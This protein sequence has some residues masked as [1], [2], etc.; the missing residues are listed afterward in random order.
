MKRELLWI[1]YFFLKLLFVFGSFVL[2]YSSYEFARKRTPQ[3]FLLSSLLRF[4][5]GSRVVLITCIGA[6]LCLVLLLPF[7]LRYFTLQNVLCF[8][9]AV[10]VSAYYG[11]KAGMWKLPYEGGNKNP[12]GTAARYQHGNDPYAK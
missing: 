2:V 6:T 10:A 5:I 1:F 3:I 7:V 8:Y 9:V 11:A 4:W 12:D